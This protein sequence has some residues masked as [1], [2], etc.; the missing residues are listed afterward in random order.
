MEEAIQS[1]D[2]E[3]FLKLVTVE[4][5]NNSITLAGW[6]SKPLTILFGVIFQKMNKCAL[7]LLEMGVKVNQPFDDFGTAELHCLCATNGNVDV[8]RALLERGCYVDRNSITHN[9]HTP[10]SY[11][12]R[13][14]YVDLCYLLLDRGA[15]TKSPAEQRV[16]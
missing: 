5:M 11:A 6:G 13:A 10:L 4:N 8:A 7:R 12:I 9:L 16:F 14:C 1:R 15:S 3:T 2:E